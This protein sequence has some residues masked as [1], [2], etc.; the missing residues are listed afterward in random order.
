MLNERIM[1]PALNVGGLSGGRTGAG[2]ANLIGT[3]SSAYIDFRLV[4]DQT[5]GAGARSWSRHT[6]RRQGWHIVRD[7]PDSATRQHMPGS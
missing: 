1:L 5:P 6:S 7:T 3:E 4:P 2:G